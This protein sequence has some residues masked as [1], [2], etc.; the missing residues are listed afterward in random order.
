VQHV[1]KD[2]K[3]AF[4]ISIIATALLLL[5]LHYWIAFGVVL[6]I[7]G[8]REIFKRRKSHI[9]VKIVAVVS[10]ERDEKLEG[11]VLPVRDEV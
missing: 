3:I 4:T 7:M 10:R 8:F 2:V 9:D 5:V 1:P 11:Y 6:S